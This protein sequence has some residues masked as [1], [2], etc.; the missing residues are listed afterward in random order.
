MTEREFFRRTLG[1]CEPWEIVD[2]KLDLEAK[3]VEVEVA[4]KKGTK[5]AESGELLPAVRG[6]LGERFGIEHVTIQ[7]EREPCGEHTV[8]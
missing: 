3:E 6:E 7:V 2:V 1:L 8:C 5:W 4:V